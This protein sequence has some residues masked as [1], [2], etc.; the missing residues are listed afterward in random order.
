MR[1][2]LQKSEIQAIPAG[3]ILNVLVQEYVFNE[4]PDRW[5]N[6]QQK[7][8]PCAWFQEH[9][10]ACAE[11]DGGYSCADSV[12]KYST[13]ASAAMQIPHAPALSHLTL[14][15]QMVRKFSNPS[16]GHIDPVETIEHWATFS[17]HQ[18]DPNT[19]EHNILWAKA[20][21]LPLAIC[22]AALLATSGR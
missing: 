7:D 19:A 2:N 22:R 12:M 20:K 8:L 10:R 14:T 15:T 17:S 4:A 3:R 16:S 6:S 9:P 1:H 11:D 21:D 5:S 13:D 18:F